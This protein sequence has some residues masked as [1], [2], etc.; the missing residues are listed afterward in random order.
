MLLARNIT[1]DNQYLAKIET[2]IKS[3]EESKNIE[4]Q[5]EEEKAKI[6]KQID[7]NLLRKKFYEKVSKAKRY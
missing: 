4:N 3:L 5:S 2:T 7:S 1:I 6:V